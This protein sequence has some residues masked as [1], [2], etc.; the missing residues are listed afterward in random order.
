MV[1][2]GQNFENWSDRGSLTAEQ[3]ANKVWKQLLASYEAPVINSALLEELQAFVAR[4][5]TEI[6]SGKVV[7]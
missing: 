6:A 5:K 3:R 7:N 4:R 2:D 1:S